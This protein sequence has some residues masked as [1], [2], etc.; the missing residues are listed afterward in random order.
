MNK[1]GF[2]SY[3]NG[4]APYVTGDSIEGVIN[5]LENNSTRSPETIIVCFLCSNS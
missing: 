5:S 2:L 3:A 1:T 4:K